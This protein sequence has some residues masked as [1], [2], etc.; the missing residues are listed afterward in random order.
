MMTEPKRQWRNPAADLADDLTIEILV[1]LPARPLGRCKCVSRSWRDLIAGPVHRRRLANTDA[2]SGFFSV[3]AA[4]N[5]LSFTSLS[6]SPGDDSSPPPSFLDQAFPFLPWNGMELVDSCNGLLLLRSGHNTSGYTAC[7]P[8]THGWAV[9]LPLPSPL[10]EPKPAPL[11]DNLPPWEYEYARREQLR[12][13]WRREESRR[14]RP[15]AAA[16]GF[17]PAVSPHF[18]VFELVAVDGNVVKAVRIYSS[19]SGEWALRDSAWSYRI[20]YSGENAHLSGCEWSYRLAHAGLDGFLH[21]TTTDA[22][23]GAVVVV[24]VDAMGRTWRANRVSQ[25]PPV[26][27]AGAVIGHSQH[28]LL[29]VDTGDSGYFGRRE[30]E[31]SVYAL[32]KKRGGADRWV[33]KHRAGSLD[34]NGC[35]VIGIHPDCNV[36]FLFDYRKLSLIAYDMDC[37]TTRVVHTFTDE[38]SNYQFFQYVPVYL[39]QA[40]E[41]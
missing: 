3:R 32:E 6:C 28:R 38:T 22:K 41:M 40:L 11:P 18:H 1:R 27:A 4:V 39:Q 15:G 36:I 26:S 33:L 20:A 9:E 19:E 35:R 23:T 34:C 31:L 8:T 30:R 12:E 24:S 29:Y 7:N 5:D 17:D 16:L 37:G 13:Q 10:P 14:P 2:A 21:L 25:E